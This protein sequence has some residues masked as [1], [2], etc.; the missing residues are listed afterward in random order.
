MEFSFINVDLP[1][2]RTPPPANRNVFVAIAIAVIITITMNGVFIYWGVIDRSWGAMAIMMLYGPFA[3]GALGLLL[4]LLAPVVQR[5]SG[6]ASV[7][8]Y[9]TVSIVVPLIA[10]AVT[11][12][13]IFVAMSI[14]PTSGC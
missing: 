11:W 14:Y 1:R 5:V 2:S 9:Q 12:T 6:G 4:F 8:Y 7:F 10:F 3:N 13:A